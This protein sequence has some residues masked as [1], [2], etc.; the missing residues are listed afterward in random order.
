MI[1]L[2]VII[3]HQPL[4]QNSNAVAGM[5]TFLGTPSFYAIMA[6]YKTKALM[7]EHILKHQYVNHLIYQKLR[8][9]NTILFI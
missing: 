6:C 5:T 4:A 1:F 2:S 3:S 7:N 9:F 8:L